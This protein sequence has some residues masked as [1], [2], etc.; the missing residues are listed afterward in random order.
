MLKS[1][2]ISIGILFL[3]SISS[4]ASTPK[5]I[6]VQG[7][8][9]RSI[10]SIVDY[11]DAQLSY[12][13]SGKGP[14]R[15]EF[16]TGRFMMLQRGRR[17]CE[18][19]G[20]KVLLGKPVIA[21]K[22]KLYISVLDWSFSLRPI[23]SK[24]SIS[25]YEKKLK[26]IVIDPGH[27]GKDPGAVN[28]SANIKE[29]DLALAVCKALKKALEKEGYDVS[30]TRDS[31]TYLTLPSRVQY[32]KKK[33]ADLFLSVHF[34]ASK[35]PS[36][37][38]LE[39]FVYTLM[40]HP[41]T[42]RAHADAQDSIFASANRNDIRNAILGYSLQ[43]QLIASTGERDRGLKRARFTVL[44]T[45][46]CP[47]AL[48]ELGFISHKQTAR[49]VRSDKTLQQLVKALVIGIKDYHSKLEKE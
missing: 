36:A 40:N 44:E 2:N 16:G 30:L 46:K 28:Q 29:K 5:T 17:T 9:Y 43:K 25:R 19:D 1:A 18:V 12:H 34:N 4:L 20:I 32:A 38:G 42:G 11:L 39:T 49:Q 26:K 3:L 8:S 22:N 10:D 7:T 47:A 35:N 37:S 24:P 31:D 45:Q 13:K 23:I 6:S 14:A 27:G 21:Y 41:S 33:R 48:V 15:I